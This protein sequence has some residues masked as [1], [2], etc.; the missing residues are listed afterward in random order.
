MSRSAAP[1]PDNPRLGVTLT[2]RGGGIGRVVVKINGK[3]LTP[4]ARPARRADSD[5]KTLQVEVP[6]ADDPR[7]KPGAENMIEVQ[8]FNA[9][10][11][12]RSRGMIVS[13]VLRGKAARD[14][15]GSVG[16]RR[17]RLQ[18]PQPHA[19][20]CATP[21]RTP[22]T[23]PRRCRSPPSVSSARIICI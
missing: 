14:A 5:A 10:G 18:V 7:L 3:E 1:T 19:G 15:A 23:S 2:N 17:R 9:E 20:I 12:L 11:Y 21:P 22:R 4:D 16:R 6:L 13:Y 8:A